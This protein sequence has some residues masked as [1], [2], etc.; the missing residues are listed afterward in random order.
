MTVFIPKPVQEGIISHPLHIP[1][2]AIWAPMGIGK[3]VCTLTSLDARSM[4]DD[5]YPALIIAPL[6]VVR[7]TWPTEIHKWDHL[8]HLRVSVITGTPAQRRDAFY[9][10]A[11]IYCINFEGLPW[12]AQHCADKWPFRT[13]IVDEA[14]KLKGFRLKGGTRRALALMG[15]AHKTPF[16]TELT[17]TPAPNGLLDLW[18][19]MWFI[20]RGARLGRTFTGFKERWFTSTYNGRTVPLPHARDEILKAVADVVHIVSAEDWFDLDEPIVRHVEV[21]LPPDAMRIYKKMQ[22]DLFVEI[23]KGKIISAVHAGAAVQKC[24]QLAS[25]AVYDAP[26]THAYHVIH[27][28]KLDALESIVE[29]AAGAPILVSYQFISDRERILKRFKD[30]K[31]LGD[32]PATIDA[33]NRGEIPMLLVHPKSAGHGLNL[34]YGGNILVFFSVGYNFEEHAQVIER[35]GPMRQMQAGLKRNVFIY[36]ITAADTVENLVIEAL[37]GKQELHTVLMRGLRSC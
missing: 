29:E 8:R 21:T 30:A 36:V 22:K 14:T 15:V 34:Q 6:R 17:G 7:S 9:R 1:R 4:L 2:G 27:D 5:C 10:P 12:L 35:I 3:T 31:L 26:E 28:E 11:E 33:W 32:D 19:Q 23:T 25:G 16:W 20:D 37:E 13:V 18:G 24:L